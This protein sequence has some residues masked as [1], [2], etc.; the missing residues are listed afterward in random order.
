MSGFPQHV[1]EA[2]SDPRLRL[3]LTQREADLAE[4]LALPAG[5]RT[6]GWIVFELCRWEDPAFTGNAY[7][8]ALV[9]KREVAK[10]IKDETRAT[11]ELRQGWRTLVEEREEEE[12]RHG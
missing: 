9:G 1:R 10:A 12:A 7:A 3:E 4:L 6:L 11:R 5:R 8:Y 2:T